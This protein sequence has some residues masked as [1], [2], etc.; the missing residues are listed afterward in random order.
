MSL[1]FIRHKR[2]YKA[3]HD[4]CSQDTLAANS[5][6]KIDSAPPANTLCFLR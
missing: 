3:T 1:A 2:V 5:N 4:S 6:N